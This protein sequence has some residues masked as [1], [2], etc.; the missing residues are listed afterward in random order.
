MRSIRLC[1]SLVLL[2]GIL[3]VSTIAFSDSGQ[4]QTSTMQDKVA[5]G[6]TQGS[7]ITKKP[8]RAPAK[9]AGWRRFSKSG[10]SSAV[11]PNQSG[12]WHHFGGEVAQPNAA[13]QV[14]AQRQNFSGGRIVRSAPGKTLNSNRMGDLEM[15]MW[16]MVNRDRQD[17]RNAEET[18]GG[19]AIRVR[20]NER[21]A[22]VARA[23][24][25]DM[26]E[27]GFF[28]HVDPEG[29]TPAARI[30]AG[31]IPWRALGENIAINGSVPGAEAAFMDEPRFE[32]NHRANIL[33]TKFTDV[34][35]GIVQAPNG[36]L[37]ITQD[38]VT[39]PPGPLAT[40]KNS[41]TR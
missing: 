6:T 40:G 10:K 14:S 28:D 37:Y 41:G 30:N 36:S 23:H 18:R 4:S 27:Q 22:E 17:P 24:S 3:S 5:P 31:G 34:G 38:F 21:L 9:T 32:K 13:P 1:P 39:I 16:A 33:N 15:Q 26:V 12:V 25:R 2:T 29:R 7:T 11:R 19:H 35:I 20:W 8:A